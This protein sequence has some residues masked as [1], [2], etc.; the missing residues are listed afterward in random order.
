MSWYKTSQVFNKKKKPTKPYS[1]YKVG[2]GDKI[3]VCNIEAYSADQARLFALDRDIKLQ[4][5]ND[6]SPENEVVAELDDNANKDRER[7]RERREQDKEDLI[8]NAYWN[9]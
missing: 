3:F 8:D 6:F 5:W 2:H 7:I 1:I 9:K 4:E